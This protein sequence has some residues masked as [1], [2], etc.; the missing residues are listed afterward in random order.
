MIPF[1]SNRT[2]NRE[3]IRNCKKI[4]KIIK[5]YYGFISSPNKGGESW[6]REKK[7]TIVLFR[8]N[9]THNRKFQKKV[10]NWKKLKKNTIVASLKAKNRLKKAEKDGKQKLLF[11]FVPTRPQIENFKKT[12]KKFRKFK[13]TIVASFQAIIGWNRPRNRENKNYHSVSFQPDTS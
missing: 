11:P 1:R 9:L 7:K 2:H 5:Y 4:Q 3:I 13:N 12:E 8:S 6:E 10:K